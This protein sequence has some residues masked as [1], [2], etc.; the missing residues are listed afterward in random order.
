M[1]LQWFPFVASGPGEFKYRASLWH[2]SSCCSQLQRGVLPMITVY[3]YAEHAY[4]R[5]LQRFDIVTH[6]S[7]RA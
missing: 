2:T 3:T 6:V 1:C 5:W 7:C 4:R